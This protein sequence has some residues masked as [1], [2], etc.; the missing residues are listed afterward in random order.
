M[1]MY[2]YP[3]CIETSYC[4]QTYTRGPFHKTAYDQAQG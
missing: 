4:C 3:V 1:S 2:I